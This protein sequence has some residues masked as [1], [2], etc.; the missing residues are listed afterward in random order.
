MK[1]KKHK[2]GRT[3]Y[4]CDTS[5]PTDEHTP[6][7]CFF[8]KNRRDGLIKVPSCPR[9]NQHNDKD[10]EYVRN[11]ITFTENCNEVGRAMG[12]VAMRSLDRSPK[13]LLRTFKDSKPVM[14]G[15]EE[16]GTVPMDMPRFKKVMRAI[17]FGLHFH[18]CG[19]RY[20]HDWFIYGLSMFNEKNLYDG[21]RDDINAELR[22]LG[23]RA[24]YVEQPTSHPEVFKYGIY[25]LDEDRLIYR[26]IFYEGYYVIAIGTQHVDPAEYKLIVP[27][28]KLWIPNSN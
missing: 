9:H 16:V 19:V 25:R 26:L 21:E 11:C 5:G 4:A 10:V 24:P 2:E 6:P 12:E 28:V 1:R 18:D 22:S 8:P 20:K 3:C 13:L 17:A 15:G 27:E 14:I 23:A 7:Q